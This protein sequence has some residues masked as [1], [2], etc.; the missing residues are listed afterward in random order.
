MIIQLNPNESFP[1]LTAGQ[2]YTVLGIEADDFRILDDQGRP[3]LYPAASFTVVDPR[4]PSD[5]INES[6]EDRERYAYPPPLNDIGFFEDFFDGRAAVI[7]A[8][9]R[10]MNQRLASAA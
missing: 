10:A 4:E 6:G 9:W 1:G 5:W 7:A 2:K 3:Y 8:F